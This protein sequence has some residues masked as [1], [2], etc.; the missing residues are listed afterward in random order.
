MVLKANAFVPQAER[1]TTPLV[2]K[3]TAGLRLLKGAEADNLLNAV[4]GVFH[5]SGYM[6]SGNAVEIMDG[7][8]EGI[9]SWFAINYLLGNTRH[10]CC[11]F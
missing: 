11:F 10:L 8:D 7:T 2:L 3:A 1:A 5:K 6:I 9:F 4:R